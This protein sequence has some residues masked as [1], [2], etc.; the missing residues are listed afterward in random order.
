[1]A[2]K[3]LPC[4][5]VLR[6]LLRYDP[7]T[8][9]LFWRERDPKWFASTGRQTKEHRAANWN[10]RYANKEAFT[11]TALGYRVGR[12]FDRMHRAH[13]VI[14]AME[15]GSWPVGEIDHINGQRDDN[16]LS[17]LRDVS[18]SI[19]GRNKCLRSDN[20]SGHQ[21]IYWSAAAGKWV[22]CAWVDGTYHYFGLHADLSDAVAARKVADPLLG[23]HENHGRK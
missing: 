1:M 6:Q 10:S 17:N 13:R 2:H 3:A 22:S 9:K 8:G 23:F 12:I 11:A 4:P 15:I 20:T 7:E 5:T 14:W 19:N 16:R 21:G 18:S